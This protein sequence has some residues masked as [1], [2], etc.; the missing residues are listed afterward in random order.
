[1]YAYLNGIIADIEEDNCIIDVND[2]GYNVQISG[3]TLSRLP[4]IGERVKLY[5]YTNVKEDA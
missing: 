1:M 2:I 4:G 3:Q 5:T